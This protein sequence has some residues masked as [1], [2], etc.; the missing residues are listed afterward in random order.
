MTFEPTRIGIAV[1]E[2]GG[3]FLVGTRG[4]TSSLAGYSEFPGGK[5]RDGESPGEC[6]RRECFEETGLSVT[7]G[8]LLLRCRH[9]Y[10]HGDV[11]LFFFACEP[12]NGPPANTD[13]RGFRW[14]PR[15]HLPL[16]RF[17]EAN[18]PVIERLVADGR[19]HS[20]ADGRGRTEAG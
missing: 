4:E 10:G 19:R 20:D 17:P 5:C 8:E 7:V 1:V 13:R 11:D 9:R 6:A 14:V 3:C 15:E 16:L 2:A 18:Q 12:S